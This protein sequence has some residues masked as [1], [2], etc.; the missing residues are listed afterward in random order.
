ME[1]AYLLGAVE[2]FT[3]FFIMLGP[4]RLLGPF[5]QVTKSLSD[6]EIHDIAWRAGVLSAAA[7][8]ACGLVGEALLIKWN[9]PIPILALTSGLIFFYIAFYMIVA[10]KQAAV[11]DTATVKITGLG[12][13]LSMIITPYGAAILI[14]LLA[15]SEGD[16]QREMQIFG[17]LL[18]V[19]FLNFLAMFFIRQI[20]HKV[21]MM[22]L[23]LLGVVLGVLQA[24]LAL[25]LIYN[26]LK[27]LYP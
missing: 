6:Q 3:F 14:G 9:I 15:L 26:S 10:P 20:M 11:C 2:I 4:L 27:I 19:L 12:T 17:I 23:Q 1:K 18:A 7:L 21:V 25:N 24:A 16:T 8:I 5:S 13:A 22:I